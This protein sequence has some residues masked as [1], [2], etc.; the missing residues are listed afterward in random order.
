[1]E[2]RE[3]SNEVKKMQIF[4]LI[5]QGFSTD[6]P[7]IINTCR[8]HSF[9]QSPLSEDTSSQTQGVAAELIKDSKWPIIKKS[10]QFS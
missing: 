4:A 8:E 5:C 3:N 10:I 9:F 7:F 1:M 6:L 2:S